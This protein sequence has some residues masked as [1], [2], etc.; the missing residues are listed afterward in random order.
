MEAF[1]R[2]F[3][4]KWQERDE[5]IVRGEAVDPLPGLDG[6][7]HHFDRIHHRSLNCSWVQA[8]LLGRNRRTRLRLK[9]LATIEFQFLARTLDRGPLQPRPER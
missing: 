7:L 9:A 2:E 3:D 6:I 4:R 8:Q 1:H 5:R